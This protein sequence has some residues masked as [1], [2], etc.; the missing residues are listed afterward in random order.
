[1]KPHIISLINAVI[2]ILISS[3]GYFSSE[4]PSITALIPAS[5]GLIILLLHKG[6][7]NENKTIAHIV[8]LL[9]LIVLIGLIRPLTGAIERHDN[10]AIIRVSIMIISTLIALILFVKNFIDVR[11]NKIK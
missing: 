2:L 11:K 6:L 7:K 9:T 8:V 10:F 1:M 4:T 5:I 3:W